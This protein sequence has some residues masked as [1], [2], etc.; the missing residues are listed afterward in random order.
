MFPLE[1]ILSVALVTLRSRMSTSH[2]GSAEFSGRCAVPGYSDFLSLRYLMPASYENLTDDCN[3]DRRQRKPGST[4]AF[5]YHW[6]ALES[7]P[8]TRVADAAG[9]APSSPWVLLYTAL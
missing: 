8:V 4:K 2:H 9:E 1:L 5:G 3:T 6:R 7:T